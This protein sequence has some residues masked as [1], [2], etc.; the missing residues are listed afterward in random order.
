MCILAE[1]ARCTA[2]DIMDAKVAFYSKI[3]VRLVF[4]TITTFVA[5]PVILEFRSSQTSTHNII[6]ADVGLFS[7][8]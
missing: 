7:D 3:Y 2:Y 8:L 5:I 1:N 4:A 6:H